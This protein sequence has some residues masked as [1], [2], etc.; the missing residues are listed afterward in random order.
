MEGLS[1]LDKEMSF[2]DNAQI[3]DSCTIE[4]QGLM[5]SKFFRIETGPLQRNAAMRTF[6]KFLLS[7][8]ATGKAARFVGALAWVAVALPLL[9]QAAAT[10]GE[11]AT[12]GTE[13]TPVG[14]ERAGNATG[15]I[16]PYTGGLQPSS[17]GERP[18]GSRPVDPF[19]GEKPLRVLTGSTIGDTAPLL[20]AGTRELLQ[21]Y[22]GFRV[23]VYPAHRTV[24]YPE[25]L[26][27]NTRRNATEA[28]TTDAGLGLENLRAGVPF[29]IPKDGSEV[30][31]NHRLR[32]LGRAFS[33]KVDNWLVTPS[34]E[35]TL[36]ANAQYF[37]EY[38]AFGTKSDAVLQEGDT[39]RKWKAQFSGPSRR[40]G[41]NNLVVDAIN[42]LRPGK[43][44]WVYVP[45]QRR[46]KLIEFPD[47]SLNGGSS[48]TYA[49]DDYF[50]HSGALD[51]FDVKLLGKREMLL[52]YNTYRLSY[53][54]KVDEVLNAGH[55]NP[56]L[57][58]WELHR[59]WV[60][61]TNLKPGQQHLYS[62]RVFYVDEDS[63]TALASDGYDANGKLSRSVFGFLYYDP[64]AGT[65]VSSTHAAYDFGT[66][67]YFLGFFAG[68]NGGVRH[69]E[70][71]PLS[72]WSVDA[73]AGAGLR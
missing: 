52:P 16:P 48:G 7:I 5:V 3:T 43:R 46:V 70:P 50:V 56:D 21:R 68:H 72:Q 2:N 54:P 44:S 45:G 59:V 19:A 39:W 4:N 8:W 64:D 15:S 34:G 65:P 73:L 26:V 41:E 60:V 42:P 1:S 22:P 10:Q 61:E 57:L 6:E 30:M 29:P 11:A 18:G 20:T 23:D 69:I 49:N 53:H 14:A 33:A 51:R 27:A 66:G 40:A 62:R 67:N 58:R 71:L 9:A 28:R 12:L 35:R 25:H 37:E 36:M 24:G 13:L 17:A 63:W 32:Y 55:I 31:W 47:A 38:P